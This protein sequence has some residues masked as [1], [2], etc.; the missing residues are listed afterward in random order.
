MV[1]TAAA[2]ARNDRY[3]CVEGEVMT[4]VCYRTIC[5]RPTRA[6]SSSIHATPTQRCT[7]TLTPSAAPVI[8]GVIQS[9]HSHLPLPP[10]PTL[11]SLRVL[12]VNDM[13]DG[14]IALQQR[15]QEEQHQYHQEQQRQSWS[16]QSMRDWRAKAFAG[17]PD[18]QLVQQ[19]QRDLR[20][21]LLHNSR[22]SSPTKRT[23]VNQEEERGV[24]VGEG[25]GYGGS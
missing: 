19:Q 1:P 18:R 16:L 11:E 9:P 23:A 10:L 3:V 8:G 21:M 12:G 17:E 20:R 4:C 6:L 25:G 24:G 2:A 5:S 14:A 13:V 22:L 7:T 15:Q